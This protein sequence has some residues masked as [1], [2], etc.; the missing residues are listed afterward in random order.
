MAFSDGGKTVNNREKMYKQ[1]KIEFSES[2]SQVFLELFSFKS[3]TDNA[4]K[5][6]IEKIAATSI[7][8]KVI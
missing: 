6:V 8:C 1:K 3:E 4:M 5:L 7:G 2:F